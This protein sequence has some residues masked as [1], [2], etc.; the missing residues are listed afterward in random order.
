MIT[1]MASEHQSFSFKFSTSFPS[2][3]SC[4]ATFMARMGQCFS[5]SMDAVGID[6]SEGTNWEM[7]ED[8]ETPNGSYCFSDGVGRISESLARQVR[9]W[10]QRIETL[11]VIVIGKKTWNSVNAIASSIAVSIHS[12]N[13][14][15]IIF[16][17]GDFCYCHRFYVDEKSL[18]CIA[19][20]HWSRVKSYCVRMH[21]ST[22]KNDVNQLDA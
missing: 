3:L 13:V 10:T 7:D 16:R 20:A 22:L 4:V 21:Y 1:H 6:V 12:K 11:S 17:T 8:I 2:I 18:L 14:R 5:T 9:I 19:H 15:N